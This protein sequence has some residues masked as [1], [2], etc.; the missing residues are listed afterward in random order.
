MEL[1][2]AACQA[3]LHAEDV[4][5]DLGLAKCP[6]CGAT[7]RLA[8]HRPKV[9][10][11]ARLREEEDDQ[12]IVLSWRWLDLKHVSTVRLCVVWNVIL[13]LPLTRGTLPGD[14]P[15]HLPNVGIGLYLGYVSLAGLLNT[16]RVEASQ[17]GLIIR[18][19]PLPWPGN[20]TIP[21]HTLTQLYCQERGGRRGILPALARVFLSSSYRLLALDAR[22]REVKLLSGIADKE[23]ALYL[24]QALE[25]QLG[26]ED[27]PVAGE[28][29]ERM[30]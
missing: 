1:H 5:V 17:R 27:S 18:Q 9:A 3:A 19:G 28:L 13:V 10:R 20:R 11:P 26:I 24:E 8:P 22:G 14:W 7:R 2:C 4:R 23:Q 29:A 21:C 12:R 25:R 30:T 6:R 16:T 15:M